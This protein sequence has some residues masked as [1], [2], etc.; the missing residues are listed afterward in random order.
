MIRPALASR[1]HSAAPE[2]ASLRGEHFRTEGGINTKN[3]AV[4]LLRPSCGE[5]PAAWRGPFSAPSLCSPLI[6]G[7]EKSTMR[8]PASAPCVGA[9]V[10]RLTY[11]AARRVR[12]PETPGS[13][14]VTPTVNGCRLTRRAVVLRESTLPFTV[15]TFRRDW[16]L[17]PEFLS[18]QGDPKLFNPPTISFKYI[19][20]RYSR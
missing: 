12:K 5:T 1:S 11:S 16:N 10:W 17:G 9:P 4:G 20:R 7:V 13:E 8:L 18:K 6:R 3:R 19:E 15:K 14:P 2:L